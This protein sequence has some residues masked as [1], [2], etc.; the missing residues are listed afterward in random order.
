MF[1]MR[2]SPEPQTPSAVSVDVPAA[3]VVVVPQR[4]PD[5]V[6]TTHA[7]GVVE[8]ATY[9]VPDLAA[10]SPEEVDALIARAEA[11]RADG[12]PGCAHLVVTCDLRSGLVNHHVPCSTGAEALV[13]ARQ[14]V[15]EKR[16][17]TPG[18]PFTVR[19]T[20][21]LPHRP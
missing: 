18:R 7:C 20:P 8:P 12:E 4:R 17:R 9:E 10:L 21:L 5:D 16:E 2:K 1:K 3:A 14:L 19:V 15:A 6:P 13:L 11:E